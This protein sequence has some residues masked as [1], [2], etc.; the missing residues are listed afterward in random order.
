MFNKLKS[1]RLVDKGLKADV[2]D[3]LDCWDDTCNTGT[4]HKT[5]INN[6]RNIYIRI[7]IEWELMK[8]GM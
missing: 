3:I 7:D 6:V 8:N 1:T 2:K 5:H 4:E